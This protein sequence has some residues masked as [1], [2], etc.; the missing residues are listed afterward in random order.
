MF[1]VALLPR[2][3]AACALDLKHKDP[4]IRIA[5]LKDLARTAQEE[6]R[7]ERVS[8]LV[9]ALQDT[10][11]QVRCQ[12]L[13][14]L[15]DYKAT[16]ARDPVLPLLADPEMKVRQMAVVCLGEIADP[17]DHEVLGRLASL[18]RAGH[19]SLRYQALLAHSHLLPKQAAA[20]LL[21]A[22]KDADPEIRELALR[23]VD[24]V[25]IAGEQVVSEPL[26]SEIKKACSDVVPQVRLM[27]QIL[28]ADLG[29]DTPFDLIVEVVS[30]SLRT[31]EPRDEQ[32]AIELAGKRRITSAVAGLERRAF[33]RFFPSFDPFRWVALGAL[34][35]LGHERARARLIQSLRARSI[36]D[37]TLAVQT[38]GEV[39]EASAA[40][41]LR[42]LVGQPKRVDQEVLT[43][44]LARLEQTSPGLG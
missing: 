15:A 38:L 22:M 26:A 16:E 9:S 44:A 29:F 4:K 27:A 24:E 28:A 7:P 43:A 18:L 13:L 35:R 2:N 33:G 19:P 11:P 5:V 32:W 10:E 37:R 42:S 39:G 40:E 6:E 17:S 41:L 8:L 30:G 23:L 36:V 21:M 3:L 1:E 12:A 31:R 34:A 25:L 20:D 14:S